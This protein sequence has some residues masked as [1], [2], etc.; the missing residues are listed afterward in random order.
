MYSFV[1]FD[2]QY[3]ICF[4]L[5]NVNELVKF[6]VH[7][8]IS[9]QH[10]S[11]CWFA[12]VFMPLLIVAEWVIASIW[13]SEVFYLLQFAVAEMTLKITEGHWCWHC[14][15][16]RSYMASILSR[17]I[18]KILTTGM[19]YDINYHQV[20]IIICYYHYDSYTTRIRNTD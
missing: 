1:I 12:W 11:K 5:D 4:T 6:V 19:L 16:G 10:G 7:K 20:I 15:D 9:I 17:A 8:G 13:F 14:M 2:I 18:Y 3:V